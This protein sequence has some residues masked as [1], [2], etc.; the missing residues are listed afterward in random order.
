MENKD[1]PKGSLSKAFIEEAFEYLR[2]DEAKEI[3]KNNLLNQIVGYLN[4]RYEDMTI[5]YSI[6]G[7]EGVFKIEGGTTEERLEILQ[8]LKSM[9]LR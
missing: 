4:S 6:E 3:S 9:G 2:S 8:H 7:D 1:A 5:S